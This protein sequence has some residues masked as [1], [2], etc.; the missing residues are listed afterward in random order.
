MNR[1]QNKVVLFFSINRRNR[2]WISLNTSLHQYEV[3]F[4]MFKLEIFMESKKQKNWYTGWWRICD[5]LYFCESELLDCLNKK[6]QDKGKL[7]TE[8]FGSIKAFNVKFSVWV[9]QM[10]VP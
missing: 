8:M 5:L 3:L 2:K 6:L 9:S 1:L 10:W 4:D 7:I